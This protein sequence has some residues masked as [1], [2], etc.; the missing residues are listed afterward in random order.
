MYAK[1]TIYRILAYAPESTKICKIEEYL[2]NRLCIKHALMAESCMSKMFYF[3]LFFSVLLLTTF[4]VVFKCCIA[5][6]WT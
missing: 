4:I 3:L 5:I 2:N 1:R 6:E